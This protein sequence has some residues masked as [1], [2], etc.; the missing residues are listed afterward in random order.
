RVSERA[1]GQYQ[2]FAAAATLLRAD[3]RRA[4]LFDRVERVD[5]RLEH[6]VTELRREVGIKLAHL[7]VCPSVE[8]VTEPEAGESDASAQGGAAHCRVLTGHRPVADDDTAIGDAVGDA[9]AGLPGNCV[10]AELYRRSAGGGP[11][12]L[13][14]IGAV[15]EHD[16]CAEVAQLPCNIVAANDV[17]RAHPARFGQHDHMPPDRRICDV[18]DHPIPRGAPDV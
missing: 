1:V 5:R 11:G 3:Q 10:D 14:Q 12:P 8:A 13:D 18:L 4:D 16:V 17:D 9:P 2:H 7:R 15:F 6:T